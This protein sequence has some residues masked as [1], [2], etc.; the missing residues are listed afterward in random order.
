MGD[1]ADTASVLTRLRREDSGFGL[2]ELLMAMVVLNIGILAT[3]AA[4]NSGALALQ[5]AS[6]LA[7]AATLA[8][9]QMELYRAIRYEEIGLDE[10]AASAADADAVYRDDPAR[11]YG[12]KSLFTRSCPLTGGEPAECSP[13]RTIHGPDG[14]EYRLD[15]Y[16]FEEPPS[17][18]VAR[19]VKVV[20]IVVRQVPDLA[21]AIVRAQSTFDQSTGS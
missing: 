11:A 18:G 17:A 5:R 12:E 10:T 8:D 16:I 1:G 20:T 14:K 2:V 21:Q 4:F 7:T 15:V 3:I 13:S 6:R 19:D 9:T